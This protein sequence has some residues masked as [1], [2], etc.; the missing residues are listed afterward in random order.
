[1][2]TSVGGDMVSVSGRSQVK[3]GMKQRYEEHS[4][5]NKL[6]SLSQRERGLT[7]GK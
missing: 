4:F 7:K 5:A 1:M 6:G 2:E 3:E